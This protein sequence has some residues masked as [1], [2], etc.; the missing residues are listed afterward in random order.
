MIVET[1]RYGSGALRQPGNRRYDAVL[2]TLNIAPHRS[3]SAPDSVQGRSWQNTFAG[4]QKPASRQKYWQILAELFS[5]EKV[6]N[7]FF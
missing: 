1:L 5:H 4:R 2:L 6:G 3:S 7:R